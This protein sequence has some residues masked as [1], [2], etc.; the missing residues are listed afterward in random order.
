M[1]K[2]I[3]KLLTVFAFLFS[4]SATTVF[5]AS[6]AWYDKTVGE[7]IE[8]YVLQYQSSDNDIARNLNFELEYGNNQAGVSYR[9]FKSDYS[10]MYIVI[11]SES[12]RFEE[13]YLL[14]THNVKKINGVDVYTPKKDASYENGPIK[15][16][17]YNTTAF[18]GDLKINVAAGVALR[19]DDIAD[20]TTY[21]ALIEE[22]SHEYLANAL[23]QT[24]ACGGSKD[25][26]V[27]ITKVDGE[28]EV[29]YGDA[30]YV[31]AKVGDVLKMGDY[32]STGFDSIAEFEILEMGAV[33]EVR[34]MTNFSVSQLFYDGNLARTA[35]NLRK[36]EVVTNVKPEKGVK[37]SFQIVT[38]TAT[39]GTRGTE[40]M[41]GVDED[42]GATNVYVYEG[43]LDIISNKTGETKILNVDE[44]AYIGAA[45][46]VEILGMEIDPVRQENILSEIIKDPGDMLI[47]GAVVLS[48]LL[49]IAVVFFVK[50]K[51]VFGLLFMILAIGLLVAGTFFMKE[52]LVAEEEVIR[53]EE[54]EVAEP[55][56]D[57]EEEVEPAIVEEEEVISEEE[58]D[59][60]SPPDYAFAVNLTPFNGKIDFILDQNDWSEASYPA[61]YKLSDL[62]YSSGSCPAGS[63][64]VFRINLYSPDS[65]LEI[66]ESPLY[67]GIYITLYEFADGG[68]Y[69]LEWPNGF[70]PDE[71]TGID[72][73]YFRSVA[74]T[75]MLQFGTE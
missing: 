35:I 2:H 58:G 1:K 45:G 73:D 55:E 71:I 22:F 28:V 17:A 67:E 12:K 42:S 52:N 65:M 18:C 16:I 32:I 70:Y 13:H 9:N 21:F 15:G 69:V 10:E 24:E 37:A 8:N 20:S 38:P 51:I 54:E 44:K 61:C 3:I 53:E 74:E 23:A 33:L 19:E 27:K 60:K 14:D 7:I 50:R 56:E 36:G 5:G 49:L 40:F 25:I 4:I 46:Q 62:S 57:V 59:I 41:V 29:K 31:P 11:N 75:F 39:I 6:E 68:A 63:A 43:A 34:Q 47:G 72:E 26:F 66:M 30:G 48:V 64:E